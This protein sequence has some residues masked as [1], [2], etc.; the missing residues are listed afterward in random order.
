M[1]PCFPYCTFHNGEKMNPCFPYC[2]FYNGENEPV[3]KP[4]GL[5]S[6]GAVTLRGA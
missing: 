2:T 6:D 3:F 5:N 1:N 4:I